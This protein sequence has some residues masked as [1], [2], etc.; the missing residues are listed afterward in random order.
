MDENQVDLAALEIYLQYLREEN[1]RCFLIYEDEM[2]NIPNQFASSTT[3]QLHCGR[4][5]RVTVATGATSGHW[6]L[7][8]IDMA[9]G[10]GRVWWSSCLFA[11]NIAFSLGGSVAWAILVLAKLM[12]LTD[13]I[14]KKAALESVRLT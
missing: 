14:R 12:H 8:R 9:R 10:V 5:E 7:D 4:L 1:C 13:I 3:S 11:P 6:L 2:V